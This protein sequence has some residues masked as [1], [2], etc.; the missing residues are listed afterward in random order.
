MKIMDGILIVVALLVV[1]S[2]YRAHR[3]KDFAFNLL[4]LFMENGRLSR[5]A[6][7]F[8][9]TLIITSWIMVRL[10]LDGKLNEGYFMAYGGMWVAGI[11]AKLFSTPTATSVETTTK[12]TSSPV[13]GN[14]QAPPLQPAIQAQD[15][16][17]DVRGDVTMEKKP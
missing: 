8:M 6:C 16:K 12:T 1:L 10:A 15:V 5:L 4:D 7:G 14:G 9:I 11:V 3:D 2:F 13:A 17:M